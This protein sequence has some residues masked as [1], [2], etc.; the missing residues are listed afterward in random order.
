MDQIVIIWK[1]LVNAMGMY[2]EI[3]IESEFTSE[4]PWNTGLMSGRV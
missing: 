3:T 2:R 1:Q 4:I